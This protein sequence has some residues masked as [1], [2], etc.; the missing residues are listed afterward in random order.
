MEN[1]RET[2]ETLND[3]ILINNDRIAGYER[4]MKELAPEDSDLKP[5]FE[6]MIDE[7]RQ[8]R[9]AL[10]EE[11]QVLGGTMAEGT[12][13][14]GK[15]YRAWMDIKA[16][17]TGHDRHAVIANCEAGE[18]AAQKAYTGALEEE[19]LPSFLREMIRDQQQAL[20]Y[21]HDEIKSFRD[22]TA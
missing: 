21:S 10:G 20:K 3:L 14:T 15:V 16:I 1:N 2:I 8:A 6:N 13:A 22:Q 12:M 17:F 9:I 5:L 19:H 7:S 11:V 4:A 18:D